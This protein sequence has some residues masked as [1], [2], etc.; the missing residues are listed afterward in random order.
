MNA[1]GAHCLIFWFHPSIQSRAVVCSAMC[2]VVA[3]AISYGWSLYEI[4]T[5]SAAVASIVLWTRQPSWR[6]SWANAAV[7]PQHLPLSPSTTTG[8]SI[9]R[10]MARKAPNIPRRLCCTPCRHLSSLSP[11]LFQ[12]KTHHFWS[13]KFSSNRQVSAQL[14]LHHLCQSWGQSAPFQYSTR[15]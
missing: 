4:W 14:L 8:N 6:S 3:A 5:P 13:F 15:R 11:F 12:P 2:G 7:P 9:G 10:L 1:I